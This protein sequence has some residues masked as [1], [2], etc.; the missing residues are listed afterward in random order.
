MSAEHRLGKEESEVQA[1]ETAT[2]PVEVLLQNCFIA[3]DSVRAR[4]KLFSGASTVVSRF[5]R[6]A[7]GMLLLICRF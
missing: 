6:G 3:L 7:V 1:V 5:C 4:L 2:Q